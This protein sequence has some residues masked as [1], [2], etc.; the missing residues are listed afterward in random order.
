L[1]PLTIRR[2]RLERWLEAYSQYPVRL[3]IAPP[4]SGKTSLVL[5][6]CAESGRN[7]VYHSMPQDADAQYVRRTFG[8]ALTTSPAQ[9]QELLIDEIDNACPEALEELSRLVET[10]PENITLIYIARSRECID[11]RRLVTR[12]IA[13]LCDARRLA[14]DAEEASTLAE[15]CGVSAGDLEVRRLI[16]DTDGWA[17]AVSSAI[18][19]AA[20]ESLTIDRAYQMWRSQSQTLLREF[21][22][23]EAKRAP[24]EL[25]RAFWSLYEGSGRVDIAAMRELEVHGLFVVDDGRDALRLFRPLAPFGVKPLSNTAAAPSTPPLMVKMFRAF[26]ARIGG[27]DI[28]W[29]RRRD[30]QLVKY[31][32]L[33]PNGTATRSELAS[34]FWN[35][36]DRH[37]ATQSVRTACSTIRKAFAAIVGPANVD[38]YFRTAPDIQIDLK[39]VVCDVRRF[40]A[41]VNDGDADYDRGD[42]ED[43]AMH[44]RA[45][46]KLYAGRLLEFDAPEPWMLAQAGSLSDR[47]MQVLERLGMLAAEH[48]EVTTA[49]LYMRRAQAVAPEHPAFA[50]LAARLDRLREPKK[51]ER[52][53]LQSVS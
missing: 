5:K 1:T 14:F 28:P 30:Q 13:A 20:A 36:T 19:T 43:A 39:N 49:T 52:P 50:R 42:V 31:L 4:G 15:A 23:A 2:P 45:A 10:A 24:E 47:F 16:E 6:Y 53:A 33:K 22:M 27:R 29:V 32:L 26:E 38:L 7:T 35:D 41:H 18:R 3:V 51:V 8:K 37:L 12:G 34:V 40:L 21:V 11:V 46:E 44:Y 17:L 48:E 9:C 25:Q